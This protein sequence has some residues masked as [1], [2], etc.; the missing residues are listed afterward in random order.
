MSWTVTADKISVEPAGIKVDGK[1][2]VHLLGHVL[3]LLLADHVGQV[4]GPAAAP[5]PCDEHLSHEEGL[6]DG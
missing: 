1:H 2:V 6:Q 3:G 4:G 5:G